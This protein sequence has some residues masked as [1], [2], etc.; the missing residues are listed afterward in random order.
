VDVRTALEV[1][2][3]LRRGDEVNRQAEMANPKCRDSKLTP[4]CRDIHRDLVMRV[5]AGDLAGLERKRPRL[6]CVESIYCVGALA[7]DV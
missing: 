6:L 7:L 4:H 3:Q 5:Q 2:V 1:A